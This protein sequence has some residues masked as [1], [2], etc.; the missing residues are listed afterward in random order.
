MTGSFVLRLV[1]MSKY[2]QLLPTSLPKAMEEKNPNFWKWANAVANEKSVTYIW[3]EEAVA[4]RTLER[5]GK[6]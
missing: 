6:K 1:S 4:N 2:E 5:L 3:D